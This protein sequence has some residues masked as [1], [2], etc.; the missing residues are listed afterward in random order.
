MKGTC[1]RCART[2]A[3]RAGVRGVTLIEMMVALVAGMVLAAAIFT[4]LRS[5]EGKKRS[6][7]SVND[8]TQ[9]GNYAMYLLDRWLRS[10][11]SGYA[12]SAS[13][14][15]GCPIYAAVSG[16]QILPRS[17]ALPA[18]FD[19]VVSGV[20]GTFRLAPVIVL[21][22]RTTPGV[23][24]QPSDA[25]VIMASGAGTASIPVD[26]N[27]Y[28]TSGTLNLTSTVGFNGTDLVLVADQ[29]GTG[30]A[31]LNCMVEQVASGFSG[32]ST[33]AMSLSG[34]YAAD[35]IGTQSLTAITANGAAMN[36]GSVSN[37]NP[38]QFLIVGVGD[39]NLLYSY[40][41][42]QT[43]DTPLQ[44]RAEGV[45][46][47]HALYGV[48]TAGSI[49]WVAPTADGYK[50]ADLLAGTSAANTTLQGIT[51]LRVGL[52]MR[53][54]LP[55]KSGSDQAPTASSITLFGDTSS[56]YTRNFTGAEL[57][58]RYRKFELT[59]PLRNNIILN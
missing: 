21:P 9:S 49:S 46:E 37:G 42:L 33:S 32:G 2:S 20:S 18:P 53:T 30:S 41:L 38:P 43:A 35:T 17:T 55:E 16:T 36:L 25:L 11:G 31:V 1:T 4:V 52:I 22:N 6:L 48:G 26:F 50:P 56:S 34:T 14:S 57:Q 59:I 5:A 12:Q 13:Y 28:A 54:A 27:A 51:A 10:A 29:Q 47:L 58:Y 24:G 19:T 39:D 45:F 23:S 15:Y 44:A 7:T 3:R 40:D 8:I